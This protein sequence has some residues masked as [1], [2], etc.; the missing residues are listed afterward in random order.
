MGYGE[1]TKED[2]EILVK[3]A[4]ADGDGKIS[5]EDFRSMLNFSKYP[6]VEE[7]SATEVRAD[8]DNG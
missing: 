5:L 7:R 3:T 2:M 8:D 4:D 1:L 6:N